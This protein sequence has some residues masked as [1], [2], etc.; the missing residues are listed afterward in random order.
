MSRH[1]Y[2][3]GVIGNC[4]YLA[5]IDTQATVKWLCWPRF[6]S[7]FVFG[8]LLDKDN[9]GE[10]SI[11]PEGAFESRQY[12]VN[13]TNVLVTEFQS[14]QGKF[15]VIDCAPRFTQF[16]RTF[17]P[18]MLV[19]K[20][21]LL[22]GTPALRVVCTPKAD[23][24][25]TQ[26]RKIVASNHVVFDGY[27]MPLRLTTD[28]SLTFIGGEQSFVLSRNCYLVLTYGE[29]LEAPLKSTAEDFINRTV[30]YW[31]AWVKNTYVPE[32]HQDM[33]IRSALVLKLHQFEDTGGIIASGTTSLP[34]HHGSG[35]TWDYRYC[36]F[37]DS[38]YTLKAFNEMGHFDELEKYFEYIENILVRS[39]ERISPLYSIAGLPPPEE[40]E[41]PLAGYEGNQPVRLGNKAF[42]QVQNDVYGQILVGLLP[43]FVDRRLNFVR[44]PSHE[45][46]V[47]RLL[48]W[49]ALTMEE[50]DSGL[51]EFRN[52][53][54]VHTY[55]LLF[56]WAGCQA[57]LKL[58]KNLGDN[59][60]ATIAEPLSQRA[61]KLIEQTYDPALKLYGQA[62][63]NAVV[64]A[65][66]LKLI[67]MGYL[68]PNSQRA[69]DHLEALERQLKTDQGLFYR[70]VHADDFGK[71]ETTFLVCA[72]WYVD[73]LACV[74]RVDD[75]REILDKIMT[76]SNHLGLFSEDVGV[77]GS[78]WG[79]F[80][81]TYSHVG[82]INAIFRIHKKIDQPG[83]MDDYS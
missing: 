25:S 17:R 9:G 6:D 55:T 53:K 79:N 2:P 26:P 49:I 72:F 20:I 61:A 77:D 80:P 16:D 56:H 71:P 38:Y 63:G 64:D 57:A 39:K 23:Y 41:L 42:V 58:G 18:S 51:W 73:A 37:R 22:E 70:Y 78:Q 60:L 12:Y 24:G 10:F 1:T 45:L 43:L 28:I 32:F 47:D 67:T 44:Q 48:K 69:K 66:T 52:M 31:Q 76:F 15:R 81:Q 74:G 14:G 21:E 59:R 68:D 5:Y 46:M 65:S 13:N 34:E 29:P 40:I 7:S 3:L 82:L 50:P 83:F 33:L 35:R 36:W 30:R 19:R 54:Q 4:S 27:E 75:A 8:S 62:L 11:L